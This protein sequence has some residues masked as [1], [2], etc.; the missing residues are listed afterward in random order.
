MKMKFLVCLVLFLGFS[1]I[2]SSDPKPN[3]LAAQVEPTPAKWPAIPGCMGHDDG[4]SKRNSADAAAYAM[5][6]DGNP[7]ESAFLEITCLLAAN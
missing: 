2:S 7:L 3:P 6:A 1:V 5:S 4:A